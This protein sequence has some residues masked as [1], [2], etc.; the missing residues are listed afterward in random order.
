MNAPENAPDPG[1]SAVTAKVLS[2]AVPIEPRQLVAIERVLQ[3]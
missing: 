2:T 1:C 3:E